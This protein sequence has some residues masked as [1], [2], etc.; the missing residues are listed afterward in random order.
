MET[1]IFDVSGFGVIHPETKRPDPVVE[2]ASQKAIGI[3]AEIIRGGGLVAFP[4]ETV[5]GLGADAMNETAVRKVYAA[6]GRPS[7]N[8]MI[9]HI[10]RA[11]DIEALTPVLSADIIKLID[12]FWPGPLTLVLPKRSRVPDVTTGG[13]STV[14]VRLPDDP[15]AQMLIS[16]ADTPVAAPSANLSGRPSPTKAEHVVSDLAGRADAIL[17]GSDSRIGI[18]STVLDMTG[19]V[20]VILRPGILTSDMISAALDREVEYDPSLHPRHVGLSEDFAP[21]SPGMKYRHYAPKAEMLVIEGHP[22]KVRSEMVRLQLLNEKMGHKVGTLLFEEQA[23]IEAAQVFY[24]R[25]RKLDEKGV[26]LIRA[27]ARSTK[28][29]GGFAVMNRMMKSAGYNVVRV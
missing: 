14:A 21:R 6:K 13:L 11:S 27:G 9:V 7:D 4:T 20:P 17:A 1:K 22:D 8:P 23:F 5:Y 29:G 24:D 19:E 28:D 25:L 10:A 15:V 18:E 3:A 26:D 16:L 2:E 12:S